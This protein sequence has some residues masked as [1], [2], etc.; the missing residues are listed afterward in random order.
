MQPNNMLDKRQAPRLRNLQPFVGSMTLAY[1]K[2]A[3]NEDDPLSW[4]PDFVPHATV[5]YFRMARFSHMINFDGSPS[6][7]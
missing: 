3:V 2:G 4:R 7:C 6:R 1:H 5:P